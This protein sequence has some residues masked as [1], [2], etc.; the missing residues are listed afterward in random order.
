[1]K[2]QAKNTAIVITPIGTK[3]SS[4]RRSTEG[5]LKTAVKPALNEM[6]FEVSVAHEIAEPGSIT[7]QIIQHLLEDTI[8][9]ANLTGL[10]PNVMYELAVRHAARLPVV[11]IAETGT[12]LP[13][14]IA[15]ERTVFFV[16]DMAG[17][18]EFKPHL[19][20]AVMEA[21][22]SEELTNPVYRVI[23]GKVIRD[24][25]TTSDTDKFILNKLDTIQEKIVSISRYQATTSVSA[26]KA[27]GIHHIKLNGKSTNINLLVASIQSGEFGTKVTQYQRYSPNIAAV[28]LETDE[29]FNVS[30]LVEAATQKNIEIEIHFVHMSEEQ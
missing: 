11:I 6:G 15:D 21:V 17:V 20:K 19:I 30:K 7:H 28:N 18:E 24:L 27:K 22:K 4:V 8:V 12:I 14:D 1:M 3:D 2:E 13:F 25:Q 5:L 10:N 26:I 16:N 23:A 29:I 9:I